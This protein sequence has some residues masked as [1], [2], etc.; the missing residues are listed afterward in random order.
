MIDIKNIE[1][2]R[3]HAI[4]T[5]RRLET[6]VIDVAEAGVTAKL[7]ENIMSSVKTELEY[8]KM[9]DRAPVIPFMESHSTKMID[10]TPSTKLLEDSKNKEKRAK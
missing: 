7:Y 3:E 1:D 9:I 2:L 5:L 6:Q 10:V 4:E 8:N